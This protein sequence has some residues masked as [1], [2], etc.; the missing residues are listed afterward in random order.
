MTKDKTTHMECEVDMA[1]GEVRADRRVRV[2][3]NSLVVSLPPTL[4]DAAGIKC[5]DDVKIVASNET[6]EIRIRPTATN[7]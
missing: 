6:K 1:A 5:D 3:G 2:S 7:G 4:L